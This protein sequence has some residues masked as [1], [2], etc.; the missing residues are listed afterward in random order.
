M[1]YLITLFI[2]FLLLTAC[3]DNVYDPVT[4]LDYCVS[5]TNKTLTLVLDYTHIPNAVDSDKQ[6]W[7]FT[8]PGS[9]TCGFWP[10]ILWYIYE[11]NK[12]PKYLAA[13]D[14]FTCPII[15]AV[16]GRARS[17]DVGFMA[18][19]SIGNGYRLTGNPAYKKALIQ[20][21]DSV[22]RLF[23][24]QVGTFLSW[25]NMITKMDWSHNTII[26]NMMNME[27]LFWASKHGGDQRLYDI[28]YKHAETT[29]N[30]HFRPDFSAYHVVVYNDTTGERIKGVTHQGYADETMWARGQAW[31]IYGFTMSYRE[32]KDLR[33]LD[34][35]QK[36]AD[37]FLKRLPADMI[38][39]WDFD[40]PGIPN[41]PR[42]ASA[43]TVTASALLEL[44]LLTDDQAKT[45]AY[46]QAAEKILLAL[47]SDLY[48]SGNQNT[49]FLLHSVGHKPNNSEVDASIIYADYYYIEALLRWKKIREGKSIYENL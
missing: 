21:A 26:D 16:T 9:W 11:Y 41:E 13:A 37:I 33:F 43:V 49:S 7:R 1:K 15:P 6:E 31:A 17:H 32:T 47:S 27:L 12:D 23:N 8:Q 28:A 34:V 48:H 18:Y 35:A 44:S 36:T 24:P 4:D 14:S 45:K 3:R 46:R 5:Q 22:A 19:C 20:A 42:D 10:G 25:P 38:P 2:A 29:M 30:N 40:A 39:Y